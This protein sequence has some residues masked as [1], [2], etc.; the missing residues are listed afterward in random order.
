MNSWRLPLPGPPV[1]SRSV[2]R[3]AAARAACRAKSSRRPRFPTLQSVRCCLILLS[4]PSRSRSQLPAS[5]NWNIATG[6]SQGCITQARLCVCR[7]SPSAH[8]YCHGAGQ[9]KA[10]AAGAGAYEWCTGT[11]ISPLHV[12]TAAHCVFDVTATHK[13][14]PTL[15]FSAGLNGGAAPLGTVPWAKVKTRP[16]EIQWTDIVSAAIAQAVEPLLCRRVHCSD[17]DM[18]SEVMAARTDEIFGESPSRQSMGV[19]RT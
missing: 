19:G 2:P 5:T 18:A 14:V 8:R 7:L 15:N 4:S 6:V 1:A 16:E 12:L 10:P 9:L 3:T 17:Q 13:Y 11:L